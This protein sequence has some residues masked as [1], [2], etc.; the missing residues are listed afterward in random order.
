MT[1]GTASY[2][3]E[4]PVAL[5]AIDI[6]AELKAAGVT[7][8]KIE[9]RQRSRAY[10]SRSSARSARRSTRWPR[11]A[12]DPRPTCRA[13]RRRPRDPGAYKKGWR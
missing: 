7:A 12:P 9:G 13:R 3:F 2:L 10:V 4:E 8:L 5:N 11:R 6:L 1:H